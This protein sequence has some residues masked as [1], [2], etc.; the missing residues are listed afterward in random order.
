MA[1][2]AVPFI[3]Q[4][5]SVWWSG[6]LAKLGTLTLTEFVAVSASAGAPSLNLGG[7]VVACQRSA[8]IISDVYE[9]KEAKLRYCRMHAVM[10]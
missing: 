5:P 2:P 10:K 1:S 6:Y 8:H 7:V 4:Q 9:A 3:R